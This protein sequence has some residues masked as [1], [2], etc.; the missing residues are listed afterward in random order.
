MTMIL[1]LSQPALAMFSV[2]SVDIWQWT[3]FVYLVIFAGLQTV[4]HGIGRGRP[5]GWGRFLGHSSCISSFLY[6]R[7][8]C[9]SC[10]SSGSRTCCVS[11]ITS[12]S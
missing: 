5:G 4:P 2:A 6:L 10:S 3:P 11:S 1:W 9:C 7:P 12:T 8:L